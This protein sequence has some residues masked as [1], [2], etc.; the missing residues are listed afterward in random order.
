MRAPTP[1]TCAVR[2]LSLPRGAQLSRCW[3]SIVRPA[4]HELGSAGNRAT[5]TTRRERR[6]AT[7]GKE[8][9]KARAAGP[10]FPRRG[11]RLLPSVGL[12][13]RGSMIR[14]LPLP[15]GWRRRRSA[16][17]G[18]GDCFPTNSGGTAPV[19]HRSSLLCPDGHRKRFLFSCQEESPP[20]PFCGGCQGGLRRLTTA[21]PAELEPW[22]RDVAV[23]GTRRIE[24]SGGADGAYQVIAIRSR[25]W[26]R[27][28]NLLS[29]D[30][31]VLMRWLN[32]Y[33]NGVSSGDAFR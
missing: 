16:S 9:S 8:R 19:F 12:L 11:E 21:A 6:Q 18:A 25:W 3:L 22:S 32:T 17:S 5:R 2:A 33:S 4:C 14:A 24:P 31:F 28:K 7:D 10:L 15:R 13:A 26:S 30:Y 27:A 20:R 1:R 29:D 23:T